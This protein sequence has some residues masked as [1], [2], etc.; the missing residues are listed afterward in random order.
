M[1]DNDNPIALAIGL[2]LF[3]SS[4]LDTNKIMGASSSSA[5]T[6]DPISDCLF[7]KRL[8]F[9]LKG[10]EM[11]YV[12]PMYT[13]STVKNQ[14]GEKRKARNLL[15]WKKSTTKTYNIDKKFSHAHAGRLVFDH[16]DLDDMIYTITPM[17]P[18]IFVGQGVKVPQRL[19]EGLASLQDNNFY[20]VKCL[21][22]VLKLRY[23]DK[24]IFSQSLVSLKLTK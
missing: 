18:D 16:P 6:L 12:R 3:L 10:S 7:S 13:L 4:T 20:E 5:E 15:W 8:T 23:M 14:V 22:R 1:T 21:F 19:E 9:C 17:V 11:T 24:P 2:S